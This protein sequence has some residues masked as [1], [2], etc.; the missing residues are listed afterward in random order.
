MSWLQLGKAPVVPMVTIA[1][2]RHSTY[3]TPTPKYGDIYP[4]SSDLPPHI[5]TAFPLCISHCREALVPH[6]SSKASCSPSPGGFLP[7]RLPQPVMPVQPPSLTSIP[8]SRRDSAE[9]ASS[10]CPTSWH[11]G[12]AAPS[13]RQLGS[14]RPPLRWLR[15]HAALVTLAAREE[16]FW[17][18]RGKRRE[19]SQKDHSRL[20]ASSGN[21]LNLHQ[22]DHL[23]AQQLLCFLQ[24]L[25]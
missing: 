3:L 7:P 24:K 6:S 14:P 4:C 22:R 5:C 19:Q 10:G 21:I 25:P 20:S 13:S 2:G 18:G 17:R 12:R 16:R 11:P 9:G 15:V 8:G 23:P 1:M